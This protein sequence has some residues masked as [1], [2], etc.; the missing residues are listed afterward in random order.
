MR[1]IFAEQVF[2]IDSFKF[3]DKHA[4]LYNDFFFIKYVF[5]E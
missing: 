4:D 5:T 2:F 3:T 1:Y